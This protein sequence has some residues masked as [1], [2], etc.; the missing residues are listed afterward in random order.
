MRHRNTTCSKLKQGQSRRQR[1]PKPRMSDDRGIHTANAAHPHQ[2][3]SCHLRSGDHREP[4]VLTPDTKEK[5]E[6]GC[7]PARRLTREGPPR[8]KREESDRVKSL[9]RSTRVPSP[10]WMTIYHP[11]GDGEIFILSVVA[12]IEGHNVVETRAS[13]FRG[14]DSS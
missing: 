10:C 4:L 2:S 14:I 12:K 1:V 13:G 8:R 6:G 7:W 9:H 5:N 11:L 3:H